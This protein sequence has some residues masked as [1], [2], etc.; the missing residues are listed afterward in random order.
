ME[1]PEGSKKDILYD[2]YRAVTRCPYNKPES[3]YL[4]IPCNS[5]KI[6]KIIIKVISVIIIVFFTWEQVVWAQGTDAISLSHQVTRSPGHQ[7]K[8]GRQN[9]VKA[10]Y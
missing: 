7:K 10:T 2:N 9:N 6:Y 3:E 4:F 1:N 5:N 8:T